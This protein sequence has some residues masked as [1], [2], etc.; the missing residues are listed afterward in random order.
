MR[1]RGGW[2]FLAQRL[3]ADG[4][5]GPWLHTN[6]PLSDVTLTENLTGHDEISAKIEP[7]MGSL[8]AEDG[9]PIFTEMG[10]AI[11]ADNDGTLVGGIVTDTD[12]DGPTWDLTCSGFTSYVDGM[13]YVDSK[14]YVEV[15]PIDIYRDVWAHVQSKMGSNIGLVIDSK[16]KAGFT[17][18]VTLTQGQFDTQNGPLAFE[19]GP[20]KFTW[21]ETSDIGQAL[22]DLA[23][24]TPFDWRTRH[25]WSNDHTQ[26][27][28]YVDLAYPRFGRKRNDI[29]A[30]VGENITASPKIARAG[31]DYASEVLVLGNGEGAA[32]VRGFASRPLTNRLRKTKLVQDASLKTQRAANL[33][34]ADE[35]Q[36]ANVI[37]DFTEFV[38]RTDLGIE[39]GDEVFVQGRLDWLTVNTWV[40]CTSRARDI[41]SGL[42]TYTCTRTDRVVT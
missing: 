7:K 9:L 34:A 35:L 12:F 1:H 31:A 13:P 15:D 3:N 27:L 4:S 18:G 16:T 6:L 2:R 17:V 30:V 32:M 38:A 8:V 37:D 36:A 42:V 5:I 26:V 41:N 40:R 39:L 21:Y 33:R 25:A 11:Y 10:T 22:V 24:K 29:R 14:F 19:S 23:T 20:V 28:H